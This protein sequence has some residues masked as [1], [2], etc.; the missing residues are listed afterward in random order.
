MLL[1]QLREYRASDRK[2]RAREC[3]ASQLRRR[4]CAGGKSRRRGR[5]RRRS[6]IKCFA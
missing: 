3:A 2:S 6:R 5:H 4:Q 1:A